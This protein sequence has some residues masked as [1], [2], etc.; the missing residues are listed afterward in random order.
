MSSSSNRSWIFPKPEETLCPITLPENFTPEMTE[1][2]GEQLMEKI[3]KAFQ[4]ISRGKD[5]VLIMGA[6]EI[7]FGGEVPDSLTAIWLN[8][9]TL[10]CFW[11][12]ATS[13]T[14]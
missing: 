11:S 8:C 14:T 9:S 6:K 12:I 10:P 3:Q 13:G 1:D 5:V 4:E 7:F 2:Q